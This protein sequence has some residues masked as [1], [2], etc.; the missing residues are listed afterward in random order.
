ATGHMI[1]AFD[2]EV[3][4]LMDDDAALEELLDE[5]AGEAPDQGEVE[6]YDD[7]EFEGQKITFD[8]A[9]IEEMDSQEMQVTREGDEFVVTGA[10][11]FSDEEFDTDD[12]ETEMFMDSFTVS[13]SY[14]FPGEVT[15][16]HAELD[17]TTVT[18]HPEPGEITDISAAGSAIGN[19]EAPST[20]ETPEGDREQRVGADE[21]EPEAEEGSDST[22]AEA[23]DDDGDGYPW[24]WVVLGGLGLRWLSVIVG[25]SIVLKKNKGGND[26]GAGGPDGHYPPQGG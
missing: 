11:D 10:F 26:G 7:G 25:I 15:D 9:P 22:A 23:T 6:P 20:E 1:Y 4:E 13:V 19:G 2:K 17:G 3:L 12:P 24:L 18:W 14:T 5:M 21:E 8:A 16:H